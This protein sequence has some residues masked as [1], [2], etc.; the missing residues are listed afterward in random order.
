MLTFDE[1]RVSC[2]NMTNGAA[3]QKTAINIRDLDLA[4]VQPDKWTGCVLVIVLY[5][6]VMFGYNVNRFWGGM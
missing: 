4:R 3:G 5:K 2:Q 1:L 6:H